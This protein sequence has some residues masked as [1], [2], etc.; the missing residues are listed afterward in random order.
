MSAITYESWL[1]TLDP[2]SLT[3][4][5]N[6]AEFQTRI[7]RKYLLKVDDVLQILLRTEVKFQALEIGGKRQF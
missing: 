6:V 7:D 1:E 2:V 5:N 4:I 3:E